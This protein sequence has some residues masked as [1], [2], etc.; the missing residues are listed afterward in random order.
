MKRSLQIKTGLVVVLSI[1][2]LFSLWPTFQVSQMS[3]EKEAELASTPEGTERLDHMHSRAIK[4]GLDLQGG[5]YLVLEIDEST[6]EDG[7]SEDAIEGATAFAQKRA[8]NW[9]GK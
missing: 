1:W 2:A 7:T 5:M 6:V 9:K 3:Q 4:Q 8:P